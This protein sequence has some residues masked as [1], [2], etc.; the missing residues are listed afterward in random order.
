MTT[1]ITLL[2]IEWPGAL[3]G[4]DALSTL[5]Q[6]RREPLQFRDLA[7]DRA[8]II[9]SRAQ[10]QVSLVI[11]QRSTK[12]FQLEIDISTVAIL[13]RSPGIEHQDTGGCRER[14]F[15]V[16]FLNVNALQVAQDSSQYLPLPGRNE[17]LSHGFVGDVDATAAQR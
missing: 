9:G 17:H 14:T 5:I 16:P 15:E 2:P 8:R 3:S 10:L 13:F 6:P 4:L 7:S 12:T 11:R 1:A